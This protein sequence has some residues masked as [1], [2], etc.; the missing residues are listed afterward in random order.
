MPYA[1]KQNHVKQARGGCEIMPMRPDFDSK[2]QQKHTRAING[3]RILRSRMAAGKANSGMVK[4]GPKKIIQPNR[5]LEPAWR[6][7][8]ETE[9]PASGI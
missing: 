7:K 1:L 2:P 3:K 8:P 9:R 4:A 6:R 5:I